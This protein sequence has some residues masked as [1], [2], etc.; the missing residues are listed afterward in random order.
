MEASTRRNW[1]AVAS[2]QHAR[3]GRDHRPIGFAYDSPA[4]TYGGSDKLQSFVCI[5]VV[6]ERE[7]YQHGMGEGFVPWRRFGLFEV[8]DADMLRIARAMAA[9]RDMLYFS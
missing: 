3:L 4:E 8:G 5:G 2:A 9:D 6:A 1:I 7:P